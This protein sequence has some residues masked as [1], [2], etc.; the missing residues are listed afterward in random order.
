MRSFEKSLAD[1][2][3]IQKKRIKKTIDEK[4]TKNPRLNDS[5]Y[6]G[7]MRGKHKK[8]VMNKKIRVVFAI[9]EE[10]RK[11]EHIEYN[12]CA[13]CEKQIDKTITLFDVLKRGDDYR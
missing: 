12:R 3:H 10:C 6:K 8:Y 2:D 7:D 13:N 1:F 9:C 11:L 4:L 5:W